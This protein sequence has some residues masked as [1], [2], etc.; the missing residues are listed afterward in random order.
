MV[1]FFRAADTLYYTRYLMSK[2]T[3]IQVAGAQESAYKPV[4]ATQKEMLVVMT[5]LVFIEE[6]ALITQ[7]QL[8]DAKRSIQALFIRTSG[9]ES[10]LRTLIHMLKV[11]GE[12]HQAFSAI[13]K[14]STRIGNG[15]QV[16]GQKVNYLNAYVSRLKLTPQENTD[17]FAPFLAFTHDFLENIKQF[18]RNMD[19]YLDVKEGEARKLYEYQITQEASERLKR[20]L[21]GKLGQDVHGEIESSLREEVLETFDHAESQQ[22]LMESQRTSRFKEREILELLD[23]LKEMCEMA[24]NPES[25]EARDRIDINVPKYDDIFARFVTAVRKHPRLAKIKNFVLD[26]F[27]LYQ[28][29]HGMFLLDFNNFNRAVETIANNPDEYFDSKQEDDDI[30][31]K[32]LKLK[33]IEGLVP[34]LENTASIIENDE[35]K[36]IQKFSRRMSDV[37]SKTPSLW[38]HV[39]EDLLV[40]KV[41]AEAELNTRI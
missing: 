27:K 39:A 41:S 12:L 24:M 14:I 37:I 36:N 21:S 38:E 20:R 8:N 16:I 5:A 23:A 18:H 29:A 15:V 26:Y 7:T 2:V 11:N 1:W 17:F 31:V 22:L 28:R 40:A 9:E 34:F 10:A 4:T 19:S 6:H 32:R 25:R 13:S 35:T 33:K 3:P 30:R